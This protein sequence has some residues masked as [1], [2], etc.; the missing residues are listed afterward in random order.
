MARG[1]CVATAELSRGLHTHPDCP[2]PG[3]GRPGK[4]RHQAPRHP[5]CFLP[6]PNSSSCPTPLQG[7]H[8]PHSQ[9]DPHAFAHTAVSPEELFPLIILG[10]N[11]MCYSR[12]SSNV[13]SSTAASSEGHVTPQDLLISTSPSHC[14]LKLFCVQ[15]L[16]PSEILY[17]L[18]SSRLWF[19]DSLLYFKCLHVADPTLMFE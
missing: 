18:A 15:L 1:V 19:L 11:L 14:G 6:Q 12:P 17:L 10:S 2:S 5:W 13:T 8:R 9:A 3:R 7:P 4:P 16:L